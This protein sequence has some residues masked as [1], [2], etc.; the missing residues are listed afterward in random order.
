MLEALTDELSLA[1]ATMEKKDV[2]L[3]HIK[4]SMLIMGVPRMHLN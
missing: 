4:T 3:S 1:K 2:E